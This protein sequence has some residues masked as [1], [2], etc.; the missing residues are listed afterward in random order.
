MC[1]SQLLSRMM[2]LWIL[3]LILPVVAVQ[4]KWY[5]PYNTIVNKASMTQSRAHFAKEVKVWSE[6]I[7]TAREHLNSAKEL[8]KTTD[9][10]YQIARNPRAIIDSMDS[11]RETTRQL[12]AVF[13]TQETAAMY[14][15]AKEMDYMEREVDSTGRVIE[16]SALFGNNDRRRR[17]T[18]DGAHRVLNRWYNQ[19]DDLTSYHKSQEAALRKSMRE[20]MA[21]LS[22]IDPNDPNAKN[23]ADAIRAE[24]QALQT[25]IAIIHQR[26][27]SEKAKVRL[28]RY[29]LEDKAKATAKAQVNQGQT[30]ANIAQQ[31]LDTLNKERD[32]QFA[33]M[34]KKY[35]G[36]ERSRVLIK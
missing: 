9:T 19:M 1:K 13:G 8:Y 24:I 15:L 32:E 16:R 10:L 14:D 7:K 29:E 18:L 25:E 34:N 6:R 3:G 11:F 17:T 22:T 33:D 28:V 23:K 36:I 4:A 12:D 35:A 20:R 27:L 30:Y 21:T 2:R 26:N 5:D 31:K